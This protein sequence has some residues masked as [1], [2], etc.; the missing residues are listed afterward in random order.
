MQFVYAGIK[1]LPIVSMIENVAMQLFLT[2]CLE[3]G[4]TH[5]MCLQSPLGCIFIDVFF[6]CKKKYVSCSFIH[7]N[8]IYRQ[9]KSGKPAIQHI[10]AFFCAVAGIILSPLTSLYC[11]TWP[12]KPKTWKRPSCDRAS[13]APCQKSGKIVHIYSVSTQSLGRS[14]TI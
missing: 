6:T 9:E 10:T 8:K 2:H 5:L 1:R 12:L 4:V 13:H 3:I 14:A 11:N 7:A